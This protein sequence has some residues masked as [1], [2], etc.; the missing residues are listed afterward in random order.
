MTKQEAKQ[1]TSYHYD[2]GI[3]EYE[4]IEITQEEQGDRRAL[5]IKIFEE[6]WRSPKVTVQ[7]LKAAIAIIEKDFCNE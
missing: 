4:D 1:Q 2:L 5:R 6:R 3:N 7:V